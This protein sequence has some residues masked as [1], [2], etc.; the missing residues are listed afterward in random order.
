MVGTYRQLPQNHLPALH[1]VATRGTEELSG[2]RQ[3]ELR[4]GAPGGRIAAGQFIG[5]V[6][7]RIIVVV[8]SEEILVGQAIDGTRVVQA[9]GFGIVTLRCDGTDWRPGTI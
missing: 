7:P 8:P 6:I 1:R 9:S 3:Q 5:S 2:H 4:R